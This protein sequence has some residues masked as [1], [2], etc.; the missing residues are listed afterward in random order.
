MLKREYSFSRRDLLKRTGS[1]IG[2]GL[3]G[4]YGVSC[5]SDGGGHHNRGARNERPFVSE[6]NKSF[7]ANDGTVNYLEFFGGDKDGRVEYLITKYNDE[8]IKINGVSAVEANGR[9]LSGGFPLGVSEEITRQNNILQFYVI[10]NKGK[11]S[12]IERDVFFVPTRESA[13]ENIV[14]ILD[15]E[16]GYKT[17]LV[18]ETIDVPNYGRV[19]APILIHRLDEGTTEQVGN[20]QSVIDYVGVDEDLESSFGRRDAIFEAGYDELFIIRGSMSEVNRFTE[21]FVRNGYKE[22]RDVERKH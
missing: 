12:E 16:G 13:L 8:K 19:D 4:G 1:L 2:L 15:R 11:K 3:V 6:P 20:G 21:E 10:D 9:L 14:G 5:G 17:V 7:L 18:N 22:T